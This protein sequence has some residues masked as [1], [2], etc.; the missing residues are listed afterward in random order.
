MKQ[1]RVIHKGKKR[2]PRRATKDY[3]GPLRGWRKLKR[4][5]PKV[6]KGEEISTKGAK[7]SVEGPKKGAIDKSSRGLQGVGKD[8]IGVREGPRRQMDL[9]QGQAAPKY[10]CNFVPL[11]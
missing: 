6:G 8:S 4:D 2:N 5:R 1:L 3:E 10:F 7:G 11:V 9:L